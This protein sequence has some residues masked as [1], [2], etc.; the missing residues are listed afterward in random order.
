MPITLCQD[1]TA[2]DFE[3]LCYKT[4]HP[5][6]LPLQMCNQWQ[7]ASN[8]QQIPDFSLA[9]ILTGVLSS[10]AAAGT[11]SVTAADGTVAETSHL[12]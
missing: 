9:L 8:Y 4:T 5:A 10:G 3:N 7:L 6:E 11:G 12:C 2:G 1:S